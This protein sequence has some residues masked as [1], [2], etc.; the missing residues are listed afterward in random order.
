M[1]GYVNFVI[2]GEGRGPVG[3]RLGAPNPNGVRFDPGI[4]QPFID[5]DD[6]RQRAYVTV[7][8]GRTKWNKDAHRYD[9]IYETVR[10]SDLPDLGVNMPVVNATTLRK[11]EW[12]QMQD[13][14]VPATRQR[15]RAW[16]DLAAS[17]TVGGF[18]GYAKETYEYEAMT[19]PGVAVKD[20]DML[21]EER[22][23]S[24]LFKLR[25]IPLSITHAGFWLS[26]RRLATS[27]NTG[28][29]LDA[30]L[31]EACGRR[32]GEMVEQTVIGNL[33]GV[34]FGTETS[35]Y[36][37]HD[38]TSTEFGYQTFPFR[39]TKTNLTA[40]T[41]SNPDAVMRDIITMRETMYSNGFFGPFM[42]YTSTGYDLY[43][44]DDYFRSGSTAI[45]RTLRERILAID[46]ISGIRRLDFLTTNY[47]II[48]VQMTSEVA[49]AIVG[50]DVTT[51]QYD[52]RGGAQKNFRVA[53]IM[54]PLLKA[55][56]NGVAGIIHATS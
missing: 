54:V 35:G 49:Q 28:T 46:G 53:C 7:N 22:N 8:T 45:Q 12:I 43:F 33:V 38:G 42:V 20:M 31:G 30:R 2:N 13:A 36:G 3:E 27:R 14:I 17:S 39:V 29:P 24:P 52:T 50:M 6:P 44:D 4:L 19:D 32:I 16:A 15:L 34:T 48:M 9:P 21:S 26:D 56:Y 41:G 37:A 1:T 10:I 23:D 25:S 11:G 40:P 55:P 5:E 18:N 51:F 47:T